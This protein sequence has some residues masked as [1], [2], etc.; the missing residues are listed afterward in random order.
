MWFLY[1]GDYHD[2]MTSVR[3]E[4]W[5]N[6][7]LLPNIPPN[8]L[9][10]MDNAPYHSRRREE[11]PVQSWTKKKMV[12]WL[13]KK[14]IPYPD[15]CLK[16]DI[17]SIVKRHRPAHPEYVVD[18][19]AKQ[20]GHEV[21]RLPVAHCELNPIEMAWSQMKDYIKKNNF[22][23]TLTEMERLTHL[24][25]DAVTPDRWKSLIAHVKEKVED[26]YWEVDGLQMELVD[27]FIISTEG[28]S[29]S[30]SEVSES[31]DNGSS[32]DSDLD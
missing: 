19:V 8:T 30:E 25:F 17:W 28:D 31:E 10:V 22:K 6:D 23:F 2:E 15:K 12:E 32:D 1:A 27:E 7:Q 13:D 20:A 21:V 3:F 4:D 29:D 14:A 24:A 5:W 26:H 9:I 11:Y 18:Y 16:T